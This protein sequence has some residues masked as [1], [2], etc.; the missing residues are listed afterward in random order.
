MSKPDPKSAAKAV[1]ADHIRALNA[2]DAQAVAKTLHFPQT[3]LSQTGIKTWETPNSYFTDFR[4]RAGA[5]WGT[6]AFEDIEVIQTSPT[7]AHVTLTVVR[8]RPD[9]TRYLAFPSLWIIT[10]EDGRWAAKLRSS[11]AAI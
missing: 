10:Y 1:L 7:K 3:R 4:A 9:G 11:F 6:S 5:E 8:F 2:R